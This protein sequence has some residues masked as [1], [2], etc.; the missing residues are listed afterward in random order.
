[1]C[2]KRVDADAFVL[3]SRLTII[4]IFKTIIKIISIFT[5]SLWMQDYLLL[6]L[7]E[8]LWAGNLLIRRAAESL[9]LP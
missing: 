5:T 2:I 3:I 8:L 9:F 6:T 1:M 7:A 4:I